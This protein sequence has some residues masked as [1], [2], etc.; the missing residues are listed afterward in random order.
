MYSKSA[1]FEKKTTNKIYPNHCENNYQT[2]IK[3]HKL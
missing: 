1:E 2:E 3:Y